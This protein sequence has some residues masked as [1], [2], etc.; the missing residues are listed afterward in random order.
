MSQP[1]VV[2]FNILRSAGIEIVGIR[3]AGVGIAGVRSAGVGIASVRS[4]GVGIAGVGRRNIE[5]RLWRASLLTHNYAIKE[6]KHTRIIICFTH[7]QATVVDILY[8]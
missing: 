6:N 4:A 8:L 7:T 1:S 5:A 2:C 3:S